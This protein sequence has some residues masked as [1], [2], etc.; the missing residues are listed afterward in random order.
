MRKKEKSGVAHLAARPARAV[1]N[2]PLNSGHSAP[3]RALAR[4]GSYPHGPH[5][6][7]YRWG[8]LW[9]RGRG[10]KEVRPG[11]VATDG[12]QILHLHKTGKLAAYSLYGSQG[13]YHYPCCLERESGFGP[14]VI[15]PACIC[16]CVFLRWKRQAVSR[17]SRSCHL[18]A[19]P[20]HFQLC[21]GSAFARWRHINSIT[22][23]FETSLM[24]FLSDF[25]FLN[26]ASS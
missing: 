10:T 1:P 26:F 21:S 22:R 12:Q 19:C 18:S 25:F 16:C 11:W 17:F 14:M 3:T 5:R 7:R 20:S 13:G 23:E 9:T 15:G 24:G 6:D 2:R 8:S 4:S